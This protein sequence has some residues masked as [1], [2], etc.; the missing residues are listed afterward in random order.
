MSPE[1][2]TIETDFSAESN[3]P[4]Y[5]VYEP[6]ISENESDMYASG[7]PIEIDE[8]PLDPIR[9]DLLSFKGGYENDWNLIGSGEGYGFDGQQVR[10]KE[11]GEAWEGF[12][13]ETITALRES[14]HVRLDDIVA[15]G[16]LIVTYLKRDAENN[17][18]YEMHATDLR[19]ANDNEE[20]DM[21]QSFDVIERG[22]S[23]WYEGHEPVTSRDIETIAPETLTAVAHVE[24]DVP[25]DKRVEQVTIA[26]T[27][28]TPA[29]ES[30]RHALVRDLEH[31]NLLGELLMERLPAFNVEEEPLVILKTAESTPRA[32][33]AIAD[34]PREHG[35]PDY[36]AESPRIVSMEINPHQSEKAHFPADAIV[37]ISKPREMI[38]PGIERAPVLIEVQRDQID[39]REQPVVEQNEVRTAEAPTVLRK[40]AQP[41][42]EQ[43]P[44]STKEVFRI[45][46]GR[47]MRFDEYRAPV[48]HH[49]RANA[50]EVTPRS[51]AESAVIKMLE[52]FAPTIARETRGETSEQVHENPTTAL[53]A[54]LE[55]PILQSAEQSLREVQTR[56]SETL[57]TAVVSFEAAQSE[58]LPRTEIDEVLAAHGLSRTSRVE[59]ASA[60]SV[61]SSMSAP[62]RRPQV[63][64]AV[65]DNQRD[66]VA[67]RGPVTMRR[68]A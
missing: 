14:A 33:A 59:I 49:E 46:R 15:D 7:V 65:S 57:E 68:A 55:S 64:D 20:P 30:V 29:E 16:K 66:I 47:D 51:V 2:Q 17:I 53:E 23:A 43:K 37:Q 10:N 60:N 9:E 25:A 48:S 11:T 34:N 21:P 1:T 8:I 36:V 52:R 50:A 22:T 42:P 45:R 4:G 67:K 62:S 6:R 56:T 12:S 41:D 32:E 44:A 5:E 28:T 26:E 54:T 27:E 19:A 18:S 31:A 38:V 61:E 35:T 63:T 13:Q 3:E 40:E 58:R 39:I 24:S